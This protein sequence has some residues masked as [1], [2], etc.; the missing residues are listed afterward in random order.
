MPVPVLVLVPASDGAGAHLVFDDTDS[1]TDSSEEGW[2]AFIVASAAR[3]NVSVGGQTTLLPWGK[4]LLVV[5]LL[6]T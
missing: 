4:V 1:A 5:L 2:R 3:A 6:K